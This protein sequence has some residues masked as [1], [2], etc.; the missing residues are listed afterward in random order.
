MKGIH[1]V[2]DIRAAEDALMAELPIGALMQRASYAL[3]AECGRLLDRVYGARIVV[4]AGSGSNGGDA[5][6]AG[7]FLSRQ[8]ASVRAVL[9]N[10]E[11]T[12]RDALTEFRRSG[13]RVV[14]GIPADA[15]LVLDG[16]VGIGG[17][18]SLRGAAADAAVAVTDLFT[19]A[20][21]LPSGVD[22]DTGVVG[23]SAI[24]ADVT[25]TFGALKAGLVAG[26]G[27]V[28]S[29]EVYLVD[30]GLEPYLPAPRAS[31]FEAHDIA[32]VLPAPGPDDDKYTRGVV[33]VIAGSE[34][35]PGAGVLCTGSAISGG[36]GMVR[37]LGSAPDEIRARYP[38]VVCQPD[39][40][41]KDVQVQAWVIGPGIGTDEAARDLVAEVLL[42]DVPVILD[43]D[44]ITVLAE[45]PELLRERDAPTILTPH[46]RE[47]TRLPVELTD[48]R[49]GSTRSAAADLDVIMLLKGNATIVADPSGHA[50]VNT[51]GTPWLATA[52][53]GD[54]LSGLIGS[55]LAAG[56]DAPVAAAVGAHVHGLAGQ[57]A[58]AAGPPS[59]ADL[60][61]SVRPAIRAVY[62]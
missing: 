30:I 51:S 28:N 11:H 42:T 9:L 53:S 7:A 45:N 24:K 50:Y 21:D 61:D 33:G 59:A 56:L 13:G 19:V 36:A 25:V 57:L 37:Y 29:G 5:L 15:D 60:L 58:G 41:P 43:A 55:L 20:V 54:V 2:A 10:P 32:A 14:T 47:F 44:A 23:E 35:Y 46:D 38:E 4:L 1:F 62:G 6:F 8:G 12:H 34:Q 16:I 3:A 48:D 40:R 52:G 27:A 18:G 39:A 49:L 17:H 26:A 22:A 31:I